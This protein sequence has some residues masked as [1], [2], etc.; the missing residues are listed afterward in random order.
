MSIPLDTHKKKTEEWK[1]RFF[2]KVEFSVSLPY[3]ETKTFAVG[4]EVN[5]EPTTLGLM[6]Y[7]YEGIA[8]KLIPWDMI[9]RKDFV[10]VRE[11]TTTTWEIK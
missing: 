6:R 9:E 2:A 11:Y 3:G 10:I 8:D 5:G 7:G 4:D 1:T